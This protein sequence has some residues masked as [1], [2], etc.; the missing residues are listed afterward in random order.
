M[1]NGL[2][3]TLRWA[4]YLVAGLALLLVVAAFTAQF[5]LKGFIESTVSSRTGRELKIG[6]L[7]LK[8]AWPPSLVAKDVQFAN[9]DWSQQ[10]KMLTA[11]EVGVSIRLLPLLHGRVSL[12]EVRLSHAELLLQRGPEQKANWDF[13]RKQSSNT[14]SNPLPQ[15]Q[16]LTI[17]DTTVRYTEADQK[18]DVKVAVQ[19]DPSAA[20]GKIIT[21]D[22][23]GTYRDQSLTLQFAGGSIQQLLATDQAYGMHLLVAAGDTEAI[24]DGQVR[25]PR[26][27]KASDLDLRLKLSGPD[28]A[29]LYK[30]VSLPLPSLPP[31]SIDGKLVRNG[32]RWELS[33]FDG[34]VGD[35]DLH[36]NLALEFSGDRP[37][38]TADLRSKSLDFDDLGSLVGA[39]P[40][41]GPGE[42]ASKQQRSEKQRK[43]GSG[44]LPDKQ[45]D[46]HQVQSIDAKVKFKGEHVRAGKLPID[47]VRIDF[48]LDHGKMQFKPLTFRAGGGKV[49]TQIAIDATGK[50]LQAKL[51][52]EF[53]RL[54]L[55]RLLAGVA[56]AKDSVGKVGGRVKLWMHGNSVAA[57]LGSA[58]G[59]LYLIM[60]GGRLDRMLVELAGLDIGEAIMAKLG[61]G[62]QSIPIDCGYADME[63]KDGLL[64]LSKVVIDSSDTLFAASGTVNLSTEKLDVHLDPHPKDVSLF[65]ARSKLHITGTLGNP[66]VRPGAATLA[67]GA[68][69]A[70]LAAVAG[71]AAALVPLVETGSGKDSAACAS[72]TRTVDAGELGLS[73]KNPKGKN[74]Q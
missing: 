3:L 37:L 41:T 2:R 5:W 34:K 62:R 26:A 48:D 39:P 69:A 45:I 51:N 12:P 22:G 59:G 67:K 56:S 21:A 50:S 23:K 66:Q 60:T 47:E 33:Q 43:A 15:I 71:P 57:L 58:D 13:G 44:V 40:G 72:F 73:Q 4:A 52:G 17:Q 68:A 10:H 6:S 16:R 24:L 28:P 65:A 31:Y 29:R 36:G 25:D 9:A 70:A 61:E 8:W 54:D 14:K 11:G 74:T 27:L 49:N 18:T 46:L 19:S 53:E 32:K 64:N 63:A 1:A 42:T 30:L 20:D 55:Q 7:D 35:S 38:L